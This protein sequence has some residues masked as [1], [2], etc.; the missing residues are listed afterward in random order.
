[1][2]RALVSA[3]I[4]TLLGCSTPPVAAVETVAAVVCHVQVASNGVPTGDPS[5]LRLRLNSAV[6]QATIATT[7]C[8]TDWS[9][10]Q[11]KRISSA[12]RAKVLKAYNVANSKDIIL[13][14]SGAIELGY[15]PTPSIATLWPQTRAASLAKD[16]IENMLHSLVCSKIAARRITLAASRSRMASWWLE[17]GAK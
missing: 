4:A 12:L 11:R 1:M 13:D 3:M 2:K 16:S 9:A 6:T 15:D 10:A 14:H 17:P 5:C 8:K 7:V